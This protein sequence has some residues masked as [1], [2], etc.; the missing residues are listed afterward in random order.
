MH[1]IVKDIFWDFRCDVLSYIRTPA[2]VLN[3]AH[4]RRDIWD[5]WW[6]M[7]SQYLVVSHFAYYIMYCTLHVLSNISRPIDDYVA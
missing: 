2:I 5:T 7:L 6:S 3:Q 4:D 1:A